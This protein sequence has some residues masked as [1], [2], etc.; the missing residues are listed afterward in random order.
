MSERVQEQ[1][2]PCVRS[3]CWDRSRHQNGE[4][5]E[6]HVHPVHVERPW[7]GTRRLL[8]GD[9]LHTPGRTPVCSKV[10]H[11]ICPRGQNSAILTSETGQP[12][13]IRNEAG[14]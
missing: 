12:G 3:K 5:P 7:Q 11:H 6:D 13:R 10:G 8:A 1:D 4:A 9:T 2:A 14:E